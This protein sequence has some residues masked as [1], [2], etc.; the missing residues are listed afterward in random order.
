MSSWRG[1]W[2]ARDPDRRCTFCG[3]NTTTPGH[4]AKS[5]NRAVAELQHFARRYPGK[6]LIMTDSTLPREYLVGALPALAD[7][8]LGATI[9]YETRPTLT[10]SELGILR[11]AGVVQIQPGI[12]SLSTRVLRLMGKGT[13]ALQNILL[14]KWARELGMTVLWNVLA[15]F[16]DEPEDAYSKMERLIPLL[17]HLPPPQSFRYVSVVRGSP[18]FDRVSSEQ[19]AAP[20]GPTAYTHVFP[21]RG[22]ALANLAGQFPR[23]PAALDRLA[24]YTRG[25]REA[26]WAWQRVHPSSDLLVVDDGAAAL[27]VDRRPGA[28]RRINVLRGLE[29]WLHQACGDGRSLERLCQEAPAAGFPAASRGAIEAGL[30]SLNARGLVFGERGRWLSLALRILQ[31]ESRE[32]LRR[33]FSGSTTRRNPA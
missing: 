7:R 27:V 11:A 25:A 13:T 3:L 22:D 9:Q 1:C 31:G 29:Q 2:W 6:A 33:T 23:D 16:P 26:V 14:L 20:A 19:A 12:E 17:V 5:S 30:T 24:R 4:A 18:L 10:R 32:R 21:F 15:G 8:Q 28:R